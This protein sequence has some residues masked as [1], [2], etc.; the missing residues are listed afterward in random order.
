VPPL[1]AG[2]PRPPVAGITEADGPGRLVEN[3]GAG[4]EESG[5]DTRI[6]GGIKGSF[7]DSHITG[8]ADE[9]AVL[10]DRHGVLVHPEAADTDPMDRAFLGIE[11]IRAHK[12]A[13]PGHSHHVLEQF[14]PSHFGRLSPVAARYTGKQNGEPGLIRLINP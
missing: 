1:S 12:K 7:G 13:A 11:I 8:S 4:H 5:R 14:V 6:L 9:A 2:D 3:E 10:G